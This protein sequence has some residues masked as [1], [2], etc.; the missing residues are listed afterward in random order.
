LVLLLFIQV[1]R[2]FEDFCILLRSRAFDLL[3]G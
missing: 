1:E 3:E 2:F